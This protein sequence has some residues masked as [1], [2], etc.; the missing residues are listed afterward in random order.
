[1]PWPSD[2][3]THP[4]PSQSTST[5]E[6]ALFGHWHLKGVAGA[7]S[8]TAAAR[9][10]G[11]ER[12]RN[13]RCGCLEAYCRDPNKM[14]PLGYAI[15]RAPAEHLLQEASWQE[16]WEGPEIRRRCRCSPRSPQMADEGFCRGANAWEQPDAGVSEGDRRETTQKPLP[17]SSL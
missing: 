2:P 7:L 10:P 15:D 14:P 5:G 4:R 6:G 11:P 12:T 17:H 3:P 13:P 16:L 9:L 1:M 8:P